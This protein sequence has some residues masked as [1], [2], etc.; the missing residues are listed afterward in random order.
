[1]AKVAAIFDEALGEL[2]DDKITRDFSVYQRKKGHRYSSDD[3]VTAFAGWSA[4]PDA[5]RICDLGSGLGSVLLM[6][7]WKLREASF[8]AVEVQDAS[9]A[10]LEKNVTRNALG[11]RVRILHG[12]LRDEA[13]IAL[14]GDGFDLVTGTP[15]YFPP[16]SALDATDTQRA[17]AR[18]EY[19]G[20]VE[21]YLATGARVMSQNGTMV[22]CGE[23][24]VE[25]RVRAGAAA[26]GLSVRARLDVFAHATAYEPL[27]A[28]WT[29]RRDDGALAASHIRL[30]DR[31]GNPT[32]EAMALRA[33]SGF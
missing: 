29:L 2:T 8:V 10:L 24:G 1:M 21:A 22:M 33:F 28:V 4:L 26:A 30:R 16:A 15:P 11:D 23:G 13:T 27:F 18:I 19:R 5:M 25:A 7:A 3:V 17:Y 6:L 14:V 12:D 9:F 31:E 32:A 20:G